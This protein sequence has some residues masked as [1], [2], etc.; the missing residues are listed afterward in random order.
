MPRRARL[1]WSAKAEEDLEKVFRVISRRD[2]PRAARSFTNRLA[3]AVKRLKNMPESGSPVEEFDDP[4]IREIY[5]GPYR[6]L[7]RYKRPLIV[8]IAVR[9]GAMLLEEEDL[10]SE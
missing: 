5:F 2:S 3:A 10:P 6:V 1:G 7:Y 8:I 9:H 4:A